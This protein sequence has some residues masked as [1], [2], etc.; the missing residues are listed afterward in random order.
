MW[1]ESHVIDLWF[2][3][4]KAVSDKFYKTANEMHYAK[5]R[6]DSTKVSHFSDTVSHKVSQQ[7]QETASTE[8]QAN[9]SDGTNEQE[10][11]LLRN[12]KKDA[13]GDTG[14]EPL[15]LNHV[16]IEFPDTFPTDRAS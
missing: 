2:G 11:E 10:S 3:H 5:A 1:L 9:T 13:M 7:A 12:T 14:S 15:A 8:Q 4:T 16:T 6:G